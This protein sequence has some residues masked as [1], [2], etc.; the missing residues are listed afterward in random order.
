MLLRNWNIAP[1][2]AL[3][4]ALIAL[5]VAFLGIF[6]LGKMSSI[7]DRATAI[8]TDLVPSI[9]IVDA[10]RENMLRIRTISLRVALDPDP[11][12]IDTYVSQYEARNKV[13]TQN[14]TD[15]E[16]FIDTP[17]E[18][19]LYARFKT[20]FAAYQR[21]MSDSFSL[22]RSGNR[23]ALN[24]LLLV[25]MKPIV[26]GTGA[27]LSELGDIY[28]KGIESEGKA[29]AAQYAD[30]K[31]VVMLVIALAALIT[32]LLAWMLTRSI[33]GP[34]KAAVQAA[35]HVAE[36]DLTKPIDVQGR[37][38]VSQLQVA[39]AQMQ[40]RLRET[41][42]EISG[43]ST[44]LATAAEE[45]N[46]VTEEAGRGLQQQNDEIEQAATAVN[47]MSAAVDEVARNAVSTSEASK[48]S[49][50][51]AQLGQARVS[52]TIAAISD[53]SGEVEGTSLLVQRLAEQSHEI[54]KVL[55]VIRAI[56]E[57]TNL[58][59]LN[60]AIEAARAGESGRGFAVVADE[61]RALAHRTQNSTQEIEQMVG[62]MRSG[63]SA[64]LTSMQA[65]SLRAQTTRDLARSAGTTLEQITSGISEM[66]ERNLVIASAAEE[67]AQVAREVDRNLVNIR[68]LSV[69]SANGAR[70]TSASSH[71][72]SRL[73]ANLSQLVQRFNV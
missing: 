9:R 17:D 1:R 21:S 70:Q 25:D 52:E 45:L 57:Q 29:S 54:G 16:A 30:S 43:S 37:D 59:A 63:S 11:K 69:Q 28:G 35:Q 48:A 55:D 32:V 19:R 41:L 47:E 20:D 12:N 4:F 50:Q 7:R 67:Q 73:A 26:D 5:M 23:E 3:G 71:E 15:Y 61:V 58:L 44:Q 42:A 31:N 72:L 39:L 6:S 22:A 56:A 38:E 2:A 33:V 65:S 36:G 24:K 40:Q 27:Q 49:N 68:D 64:A 53:L 51:S 18:Q 10:I 60:A 62:S 46:A 34:L 8:E 66:Y 14:I 13:L